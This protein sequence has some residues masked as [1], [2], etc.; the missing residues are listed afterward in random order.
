MVKCTSSPTFY[1]FDF[2]IVQFGRLREIHRI[3]DERAVGGAGR[4]RLRGF[5]ASDARAERGEGE[6]GRRNRPHVRAASGYHRRAQGV[7]RRLPRGDLRAGVS[8]ISL[9]KLLN[10]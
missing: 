6:A 5:T 10:L 1:N 8:A 7:W 4:R 2:I 3:R 9:P